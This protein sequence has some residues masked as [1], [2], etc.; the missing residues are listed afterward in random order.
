[1][2]KGYK[3]SKNKE[4]VTVAALKAILNET[5]DEKLAV[6]NTIIEE[7]ERLKKRVKE[8]EYRVEEQDNY[9]RGNNLIIHDIPL[10]IDENPMDVV[11]ELSNAIEV[12]MTP[13]DV[14]VVHRLETRYRALHPPLIVKFVNRW[15]H[16]QVKTKT[17]EING[18]KLGRENEVKIFADE[19]LTPHNQKIILHARKLRDRYFVW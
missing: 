4:L 14:D 12:K 10:T 1:M 19:Q 13:S 15:K 9:T 8:S 16:D 7:N 11:M 5:L 18:E 3:I 17:K 6:I 2:L